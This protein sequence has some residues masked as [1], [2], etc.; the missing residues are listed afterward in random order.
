MKNT[1]MLPDRETA[2]CHA[3]VLRETA[4][5]EYYDRCLNCGTEEPEVFVFESVAS[6]VQAMAHKQNY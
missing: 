3:P 4:G 6:P 2:C 1:I 5:D